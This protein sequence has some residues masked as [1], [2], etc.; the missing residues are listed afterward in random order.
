MT[1]PA[2]RQ[3][4]APLRFPA[5]DAVRGMAALAVVGFHA[6]KDVAG[7]PLLDTPIGTL[8]LA[9]DWGV[10]VFFVLSGFL[11]YRP[12]AAAAAG[13]TARPASM[14]FLL[15]RAVRILPAY[16]LV[17]AVYASLAAPGQL[18]S[19]EGLLRF[20]LLQ[21]AYQHA[22]V[23]HILAT[24]WTLSVEV[25]F[26]VALPLL[27]AVLA[28]AAGPQPG[29]ARHLASL[30]GLVMLMIG[31]AR[32]VVAPL[33]SRIGED[34]AMAGFSL[35]GA[36]LP[37]ATGMAIAIVH[38]HRR[39]LRG[40]P[41]RLRAV[42]LGGL[43]S[44]RV[45]LAGAGLLLV[46]G[47]LVEGRNIAPWN[48]TLAITL[49]AG[50][51]F[52]P[53]VFRPSGSRLARRLGTTPVLV[54]VGTLSYGIYLWHWPIQELARTHGFGVPSNVFGWLV[55]ACAIGAAATIPAWLSHRFLEQPL[56]GWARAATS[57]RPI[58][59]RVANPLHPAPEGHPDAARTG[60][61]RVARRAPRSGLP[62]RTTGTAFRRV[63]AAARERSEPVATPHGT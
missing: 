55:A 31:V 5:L 42:W 11:L 2:V 44:D 7:R 20:G 50:L 61:R 16:W 38:V 43:R 15:R 47:L 25:S 27:A 54:G 58:E 59:R 35:P 48:S 19:V 49:A 4:G 18:W 28:R 17:L 62:A 51:L 56:I 13:G 33:E 45:W 60:R 6:Y 39:E 8:F 24:A 37:F 57:R 63:T 26:Y 40:L 21:Q 22:T 23:Y 3:S 30:A 9:L 10:P 12:F 52:V 53:L 41:R 32:L 1:R 29:L 46:V 34:P 14:A 36:F